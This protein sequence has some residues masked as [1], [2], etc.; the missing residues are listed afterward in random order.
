M[1]DH[2]LARWLSRY[3]DREDSEHQ[4]AAVR[5]VILG[6]VA[7]YLAWLDPSDGP[8]VVGLRAVA[9]FTG[10][11]T[12]IG[13]GILGWIA[14][15]PGKSHIRRGVGMAADY[16]LLGIAMM[17]MGPNMAQLY[18]IIMWITI[19]NGLRF[20]PA[21][22]Y[23]AIGCAA[24]SFGAVIMA[25]PY[26]QAM[27]VL[28]W[29]LLVG[30]VAIPL[31]LSSLLRALVRATEEARR[32]NEA[33]SNFLA[34]MSHEFRTPLN[35]IVGM[36]ELLITTPLTPEQRDSAEV[37]QTSARS[38][39][40]LVEDVLDISAIEAGKLRR[41]DED[42]SLS[43]LL[44]GVQVMLV[45]PAHAK[46]LGFELEVG[47][48]VPDGL[49][50]DATHVRQVLVNLLGNAIKFTEEGRVS[51]KVSLLGRDEN[52]GS[53]LRFSVRDTG[54][55]IP[56][57]ALERIFDA[58]EQ[59]DTGHARRYGGTGL[60][61]TISKALVTLMGGRVGVDSEE[62][63]GSHFWFELPF[64]AA[65]QPLA[66]APPADNVIAF[67][68]PFV[69]HRAR[70]RPLH[71]LVADDQPANLMVMRKLLE[72]AGHHPR[73]VESGE[74]ALAA[75]E[76]EP[77]D[78]VIVDLHMPG[79]S[80]IEV[81]KQ[82]AFMQAGRTRT[83]FIVLTADAT[84]STLVECQRAGARAVL[85]KPIVVARLLENLAEIG[86]GERDGATPPLPAPVDTDELISQTILD[87]LAEMHLGADFVTRFLGE[88]ARDAR[89]CI[90]ELEDAGRT[91]AWDEFR[92]SCHAL[93]G[94]TS[95]MGAVR[96]AATAS[97]AMRLTNWQLPRE[98]KPRVGL[99]R[100]QLELTL[101][102]LRARGESVPV[103]RDS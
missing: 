92:D 17:L 42:F 84:S 4:Q 15:A 66:A 82:A 54:I 102:A 51:L 77:F 19:G 52:G 29:G 13:L 69:R 63:A 5:I 89:R 1:T 2:T 49:H 75:I 16:S 41:S 24:A 97:D 93:K 95:N 62:G 20:G 67:D 56:A 55:G 72:K 35:G 11:S 86:C 45:P 3:R 34:N 71:V 23:I 68:D 98:W 38:L 44:R 25:T 57:E 28:A 21:Y 83:P 91:A 48:E 101:T 53:R 31:Y 10:L 90:A 9:W 32:A 12:L 80:G 58:F 100:Q 96:M 103:E 76:T 50:G 8:P 27:P 94:V 78:V 36:A 46:G 43:E 37:I 85:T 7:L 60:G 47:R 6:I 18:V 74:E 33:K 30:L 87:E 70:V 61:T 26:W 73:T 59:V 88:C 22:L 39:Q 99:L 79:L 14:V 64:A 81:I 65:R 40:M